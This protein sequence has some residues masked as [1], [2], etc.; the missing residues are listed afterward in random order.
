[1][2]RK[3]LAIGL[4]AALIFSSAARSAVDIE[5]LKRQVQ[6]IRDDIAHQDDP[7]L[8]PVSKVDNRIFEKYGPNEAVTT[9][10]GVLSLE[11]PDRAR[12][13]RCKRSMSRSS[14]LGSMDLLSSSARSSSLLGSVIR[15][16]LLERQAGAQDAAFCRRA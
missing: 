4:L 12:A 3:R 5:D 9:R 14:S 8:S 7:K 1:M 16:R 6:R 15:Q 11:S 10:S 13:W 2:P